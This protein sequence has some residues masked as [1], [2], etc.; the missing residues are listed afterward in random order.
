MI[1]REELLGG[2]LLCGGVVVAVVI[3][4]PVWCVVAGIGVYA[5]LTY[6]GI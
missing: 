2:A 3:G 5:A 4:V 1:S 6:F